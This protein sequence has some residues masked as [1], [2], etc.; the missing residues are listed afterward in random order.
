MAV[1]A[2]L[3]YL[4]MSPR[5]VRL[6]ADL[7]RGRNAEEACQILGFTEKVA[8]HTLLTLVRSAMNSASQ[9]GSIDTSNLYVKSILVDQGP[10]N[11]RF[12]TRARGMS[13]R[14]CKKTSHITL[15]LDEK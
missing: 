1:K 15:T 9:K 7:I 2:R 4:R 12:M 13:S 11:K 10:T 14:I 6:V 8:A 5:K 3:K